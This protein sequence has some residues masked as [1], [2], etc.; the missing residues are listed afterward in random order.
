[1]IISDF[2]LYYELF[3]DDLADLKSC[4]VT[5]FHREIVLLAE[6]PVLLEKIL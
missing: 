4:I 6:R 5:M 3:R 1:M 2:Y